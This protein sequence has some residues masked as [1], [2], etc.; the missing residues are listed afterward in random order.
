MVQNLHTDSTSD[1][2]FHS[3]VA[4]A[5]AVGV[6][7]SKKRVCGYCLP[8]EKEWTTTMA[9]EQPLEADHVDLNLVSIIARAPVIGSLFS[10]FGGGR[11]NNDSEEHI[12][13]RHDS[14]SSIE[15]SSSAA[16]LSVSKSP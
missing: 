7:F 1:L 16:M 5:V 12:L 4:A 2:Q 13:A 10:L 6:Y 14:N 11:H 8:L 9:F 3:L 15:S